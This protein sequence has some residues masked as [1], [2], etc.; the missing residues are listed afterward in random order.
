MRR[1]PGWGCRRRPPPGWRW[2]L[3]GRSTLPC[4][5]RCTWAPTGDPRTRNCP[6]CRGAASRPRRSCRWGTAPSRSGWR[7]WGPRCT[8]P[9]RPPAAASCLP[10]STRRRR[11]MRP[12]WRLWRPRGSRTPPRM[13]R[14]TL[15]MPAQGS[16]RTR[17]R[18]MGT[19]R[20]RCKTDQVGTGP[21]PPGFPRAPPCRAT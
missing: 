6:A 3:R 18:G 16:R 8:C 10:G 11:H 20:H 9:A 7:W 13:A 12:A 17:P 1:R 2:S 15:A 14:C 21:G 4:T 5:G 19:P